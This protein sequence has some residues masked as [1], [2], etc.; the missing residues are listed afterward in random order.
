MAFWTQANLAPDSKNDLTNNQTIF[1]RKEIIK[2]MRLFIQV[3][4]S[5]EKINVSV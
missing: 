4:E 1:N 2:K 3:N 5:V